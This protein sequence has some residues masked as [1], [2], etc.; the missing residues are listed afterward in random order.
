[1]LE[2]DYEAGQTETRAVNIIAE[3][4][5]SRGAVQ[6]GVGWWDEAPVAMPISTNENE[7]TIN[8]SQLG[9]LKIGYINLT[10]ICKLIESYFMQ[11]IWKV[12]Q[13]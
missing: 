12:L 6:G 2:R 7:D 13:C 11:I 9:I 8:P 5:A 4:A 1:M 3:H 10:C